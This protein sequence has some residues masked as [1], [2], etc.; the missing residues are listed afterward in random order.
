M[1]A[2]YDSDS[3]NDLLIRSE[4]ISLDEAVGYEKEWDWQLFFFSITRLP[5]LVG[6]LCLALWLETRLVRTSEKTVRLSVRTLAML[7]QHQTAF[8]PQRSAQRC[9]ALLFLY[10]WQVWVG[11]SCEPRNIMLQSFGRM[12]ANL[13]G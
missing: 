7:G 13:A 5:V 1:E 11:C 12:N 9:L 2:A 4:R 10:S 6:G 3:R 8:P